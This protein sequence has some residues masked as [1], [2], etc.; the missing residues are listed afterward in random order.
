M[1]PWNVRVGSFLFRAVIMSTLAAFN[2]SLHCEAAGWA[3]YDAQDTVVRRVIGIVLVKILNQ[4]HLGHVDHMEVLVEHTQP[5]VTTNCLITMSITLTETVALTLKPCE[6]SQIAWYVLL[7]PLSL[8]PSQ[9]HQ[10][11]D[12]WHTFCAWSSLSCDW[13]FTP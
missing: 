8:G 9:T 10:R 13:W 6:K 2:E 12:T 5:P 3:H 11:S 4:P 7:F 1:L